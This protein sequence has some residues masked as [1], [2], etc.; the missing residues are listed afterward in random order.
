MR[1]ISSV[2][3]ILASTAACSIPEKELS[4]DVKGDPFA[5]LNQPLPTVAKSQVKMQGKVLDPFSGNI[6]ANATVEAFLVGNPARIF[7]APTDVGGNWSYDQGTGT[8]P[9]TYYLRSVPNGYIGTY[10]YPP[11]PLVEDVT[12][13]LLMFTTSDLPTIGAISQLTFDLT[14]AVFTIVVQDCN[15]TPLGGATVTS[16]P[17][18]EIRYF[19]NSAPNPAAV[20]TDSSTGLVLIANV[21]PSN[22]TIKA[23]VNGMT[24]RSHSMDAMGGTMTLTAIQP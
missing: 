14:K 18:G 15:G 3:A 23:T 19:T 11:V 16:E 9:Q 5:C 12:V 24:L 6:P 21:P 7:S 17:P 8:I 2:I 4:T 1:L 13:N 10:Y 20:S 22:V